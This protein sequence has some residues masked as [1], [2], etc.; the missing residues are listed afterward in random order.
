MEFAYTKPTEF[1][2]FLRRWTEEHPDFQ[3]LY[4]K[5]A[6]TELEYING[7]RETFGLPP[8]S[9]EEYQ[10]MEKAKSEE[11]AESVIV[12]KEAFT[13]AAENLNGFAVTNAEGK[14]IGQV[15][16]SVP[17]VLPTENKPK[18]KVNRKRHKF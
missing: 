11:C 1:D 14:V 18:I 3:T 5:R 12:S 6:T 4:V 16:D 2:A 13:N 9:E 7:L 15:I 10:E 8:F 17:V